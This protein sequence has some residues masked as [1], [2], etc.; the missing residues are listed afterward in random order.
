MA[1]STLYG[2]MDQFAD[3]EKDEQWAWAELRSITED[4]D[5]TDSDKASLRRR[6]NYFEREGHGAGEPRVEI[7]AGDADNARHRDG[8]G[9]RDP[10]WSASDRAVRQQR[11][12]HV[13]VHFRAIDRAFRKRC[14]ERLFQPLTAAADH[15]NAVLERRRIDA[16]PLALDD[17]LLRVKDVVERE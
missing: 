2:T 12:D 10:T 16:G 1:V 6:Q 17:L 14:R 8:H 4:R 9:H 15:D 11:I 13:G 3:I 7:P 5:I